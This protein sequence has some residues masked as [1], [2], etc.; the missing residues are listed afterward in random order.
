[1]TAQDAELLVR[2]LRWESD[3]VVSLRLEHPGGGDLPR[4]EPGAHIDVVLPSGTVRQYSL[5]SDPDDRTMYRIAVLKELGGRGGSKE[6]HETLRVGDRIPFRGPR[7]HFP[8]ESAERYLLV[9][10]GIGITP[11]LAMARSIASR[12][13]PLTLLYGGRTRSSMAFVKEISELGGESVT[14]VPQD[15]S[16]YPD[17]LGAMSSALSGTAVYCCGPEPLIR[18]VDE[19]CTQYLGADAMHFERF[20]APP[21]PEGI[22]VGDESALAE[23]EVELTESSCVLTVPADRS[24]L[25]VVLEVNPDVLYSCEDGFCGSCE[26]RVLGGTPDHR[27]SILTQADREKNETMMICVGRSKTPRLVL[28]A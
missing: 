6:L 15:E 8:L 25:D 23:F 7:N 22:G 1:M 12:G 28:E 3:G 17:L 2:E 21:A 20:G 16:G 18:A 26:T 13:A 10:G 4:W 9:A 24:I 11:I 19:I 14:I 27:D 5:C